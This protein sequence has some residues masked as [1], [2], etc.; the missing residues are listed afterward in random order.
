[1]FSRIL[2]QRL[3][4]AF[5]EKQIEIVNTATAAINSYALLDFMDEILEKQP[6]AILIYAGHN[7]FYGALGVASTETL[8]KFRPLIK[9]YLKFYLEHK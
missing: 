8:G 1:M 5:P 7:E 2:N 6:D 4:D 9:L 3:S